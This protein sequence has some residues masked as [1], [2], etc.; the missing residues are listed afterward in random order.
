MPKYRIKIRSVVTHTNGRRYV[1]S[2]Y[3]NEVVE[4]ATRPTAAR[5]TRV[6]RVG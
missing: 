1:H 5:H 3:I 2:R 4:R 6:K